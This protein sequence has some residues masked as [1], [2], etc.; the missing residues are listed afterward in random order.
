M[1]RDKFCQS[2]I[3]YRQVCIIS[4]LAFLGDYL[5]VDV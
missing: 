4:F 5:A 2:F 3:A 1:K